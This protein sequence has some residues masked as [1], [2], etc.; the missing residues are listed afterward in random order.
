MG[1]VQ[2]IAIDPPQIGALRVVRVRGGVINSATTLVPTLS[3]KPT[4]A[5]PARSTYRIER[6]W[7]EPPSSCRLTVA[8]PSYPAGC[9]EPG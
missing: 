1:E 7:V 8:T 2:I 3:F 5:R 6:R 9:H 4:T